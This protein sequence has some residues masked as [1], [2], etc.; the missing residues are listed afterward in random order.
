MLSAFSKDDCSG[1]GV[2]VEEETSTVCMT[3]EE[4]LAERLA[5]LGEG[6]GEGLE[7]SQQGPDTGGGG[8]GE[9]GSVLV[10]DGGVGDLISFNDD[11]KVEAVVPPAE[12]SLIVSKKR[13]IVVKGVHSVL[14]K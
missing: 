14:R 5:R 10:S 8:G 12:N 2:V 4:E 9:G 13:V 7:P 6:L 1:Q 3:K 11:V